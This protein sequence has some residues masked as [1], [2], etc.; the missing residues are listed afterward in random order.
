VRRAGWLPEVQAGLSIDGKKD[1]S[2][3]SEA[4]TPDAIGLDRSRRIAYD[5]KLSWDLGR[6]IFDPNELKVS[7]EAQRVS[8]LRDQV[9]AHVTR[10]YFE[11]RRLQLLTRLRPPGTVRAALERHLRVAELTAVL[12]ALTGVRFE[13]AR[14]R[15]NRAR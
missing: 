9:L 3:D 11:R 8:E 13:R 5:V 10:L 7:R 14:R 2:V 12:E 4:G 15:P 6:L 1:R